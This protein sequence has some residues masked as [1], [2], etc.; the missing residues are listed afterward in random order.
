M[1]RPQG[2]DPPLSLAGT[3]GPMMHVAR[4][5]AETPCCVRA[6]LIRSA[7]GTRTGPGM[8]LAANAPTT[9]GSESL[10]MDTKTVSA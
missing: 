5:V 6:R 3:R 1:A 9:N 2:G 10:A 7:L 8:T 4:L